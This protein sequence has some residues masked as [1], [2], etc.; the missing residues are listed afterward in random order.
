MT[1]IFKHPLTA[2]SN[3]LMLPAGSKVLTV[4]MQHGEP[5]LWAL[6]DPA[7]PKRCHT[8]NVYGTGHA[9]PADPGKYVA[10]FQMDGGSLIWHAFMER[11]PA[12]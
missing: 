5:V 3:D 7:Q 1:T 10:T 12:A 4:Q 6:V 11:S 2:G 9:M 8:I